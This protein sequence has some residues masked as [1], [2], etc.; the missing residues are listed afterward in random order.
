MEIQVLILVFSFFALLLLNVPVAVCIGLSTVLTIASLGDVP[1]AYIVAQRIST[2]IASFPLLAIPFFVLS[3][4]LMGEGGMARRLMDFASAVVGRFHGGLSYVNT[5]TCMLF[6]A[7]SGSAAA[8]VSSIGGFM[9]PEMERKNYGREFSV[10]LTTT[11][12]T[13]GLLIPPSNI[14]IVYAVVA[15]NVSVA[16]L[17]LAGVVPGLLVGLSIMVVAFLANRKQPVGVSEKVP[18][19]EVARSFAQAIP[20]LLLILIVMGGILAGVFTATEASAV[21]VAYAFLLGTLF[22]R[23]VKLRDM[24]R[25]LLKSAKTTAV[26]MILVGASQAMS[27][28]L[29]FE[30]V[31]QSVSQAMLGIS[32]SPFATLLII[33][34]LLLVVGTFMDMTPAVLIFTPIFLP[35]V[36]GMGIDPVHFG[37]LMVTNLCIGLC[38]PPVGTCLFVGCGVGKTTIARVVRPMLPMFAAMIVALM[39]ISYVP[40][41][42]LWL[43]AQF[44]L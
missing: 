30:Q 23:E 34:V 13:T 19:R 6:G 35:V 2:G 25:I 40:Q 9:I 5:L 20:S 16:A 22:Y 18:L 27:W 7:V 32:Q 24:P 29:A 21:S 43:P 3:G 15:G 36:M 8:A 28:V 4:L 41:L 31:P 37:V 17:F 39:L 14:M 33:N 26:V 38:T 10:A 12:A 1:T 42:S 11:S 44:N